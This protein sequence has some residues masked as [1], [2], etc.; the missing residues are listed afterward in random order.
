MQRFSSAFR[1]GNKTHWSFPYSIG[2]KDCWSISSRQQILGTSLRH[3]L[4]ISEDKGDQASVKKRD[5]YRSSKA[6]L[7]WHNKFGSGVIATDEDSS[8]EEDKKIT[9]EVKIEEEARF[10]KIFEMLQNS[11]FEEI[12][13]EG[14]VTFN[15]EIITC[16]CHESIHVNQMS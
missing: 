9:N 6:A 10:I 1:W 13:G 3:L 16:N 5:N 2:S 15:Y 14:N 8:N 12:E 4:C 11:A 7:N